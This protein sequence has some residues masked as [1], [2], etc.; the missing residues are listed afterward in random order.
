MSVATPPVE[1]RIPHDVQMDVR[2]MLGLSPTAE[3]P[4]AFVTVYRNAKRACD[5]CG[6]RLVHGQIWTLLAVAG[7][8]N[9]IPA[10]APLV[11]PAPVIPTVK[12]K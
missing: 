10:P 4:E 6:V 2:L 1:I 3:M 8:F 12:A 7:C 9:D 11:P 5:R